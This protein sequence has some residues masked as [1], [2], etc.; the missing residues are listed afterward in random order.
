MQMKSFSLALDLSLS[1]HM[2]Y[3]MHKRVRRKK[4]KKKP[5][6]N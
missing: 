3:L 5:I 4:E 1:Q 6:M 2:L